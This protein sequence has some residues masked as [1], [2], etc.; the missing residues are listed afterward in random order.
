LKKYFLP[1]LQAK[2]SNLVLKE[3]NNFEIAAQQKALL[4]MTKQAFFNNLFVN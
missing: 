2:R 1:S 4:A 3:I